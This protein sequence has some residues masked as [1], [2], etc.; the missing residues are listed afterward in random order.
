MIAF[1]GVLLALAFEDYKYRSVPLWLVLVG[2]FITFGQTLFS[3][4]W[5]A[6]VHGGA[7]GLVLAGGLYI[8]CMVIGRR[9]GKEYF[10]FGDV[11][12]CGLLGSAF[13]VEAIIATFFA[14]FYVQVIL[15]LILSFVL[16]LKVNGEFPFIVA[17]VITAAINE[18]IPHGG[19]C[20][21]V[22][23]MLPSI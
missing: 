1:W 17:L 13:G 16:R 5:W 4:R 15:S 11:L 9:T 6:L 7:A 21:A 20:G 3:G 12:V 23:S 22:L 2:F 10:G 14:A 19:L 8:I 18:L